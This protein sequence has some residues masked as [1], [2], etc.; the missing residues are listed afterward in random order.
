MTSANYSFNIKSILFW[1]EA[2]VDNLSMLHGYFVIKNNFCTDKVVM[3]INV[4]AFVF[5]F[6]F[7]ISSKSYSR[8]S[9]LISS[10]SDESQVNTAPSEE[11]IAIDR[12]ISAD[13]YIL[14]PGD[15]LELNVW[16]AHD[17]NYELLVSIDGDIAIP[18]LGMFRAAGRTLSDLRKEVSEKIASSFS[19]MEHTLTLKIPHYTKI[20]VCGKV[21]NPGW[22]YFRGSIRLSEA[23]QKAGGPTLNGSL[24]RVSLI[25]ALDSNAIYV[26]LQKIL[27]GNVNELDPYLQSGDI[28]TIPLI[29]EF[30]EV[31]GQVFKPGMYEISRDDTL[32]DILRESGGP[33]LLANF[34]NS[35]IERGDKRI[36]IDMQGL[37]FGHDSSTAPRLV[38]GDRIFIGQVPEFVY[39]VGSVIKPGPEKFDRNLNILDYI[40]LAQGAL[41]SA[42][43][44]NITVIRGSTNNLQKFVIDVKELYKGKSNTQNFNMKPGDIIIVPQKGT[45]NYQFLLTTALN[46]LYITNYFK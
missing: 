42:D 40:N 45:F 20:Q 14:W 37:Y 15:I 29:A 12:V 13:E 41:P 34:D 4:I 3:L 7:A 18:N 19:Y 2:S 25:H 22:Y 27:D 30:V 32:L 33:S 11:Q 6:S 24:K 43:L 8:T 39:I 28:I 16:G 46:L 10:S 9:N 31:A 35:F 26:N 5:S 21:V 1:L 17:E 38:S 23:V 36:Q 44:P